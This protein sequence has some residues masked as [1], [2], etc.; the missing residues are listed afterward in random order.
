VL[1]CV[2]IETMLDYWIGQCCLYQQT[3][4]AMTRVSMVKS[5]GSSNAASL[6]DL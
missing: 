3:C 5:F 2:E 6:S 4:N 1:K